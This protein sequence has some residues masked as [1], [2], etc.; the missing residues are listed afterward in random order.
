MATTVR[1]NPPCWLSTDH[2]EP[3]LIR[4]KIVTHAFVDG[5][6]R[7]VTG[8]HVVTNNRADTVLALFHA[9]I[10]QWG[11]PSR[12]R[13]DYGVEN[14]A[15]AQDQE[16]AKGPGRGSYIFGRYGY[17]Q[18][19]CR[20]SYS[21][22]SIGVFIISGSSDCGETSRQD[23]SVNGPTSSRTW[24]SIMV[25]MWNWMPTSGCYNICI[26]GSS[27]RTHYSGPPHGTNIPCVFQMV[28]PGG[29]RQ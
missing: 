14:Q 12:V 9:A 10:N 24:S 22:N 5:Y 1:L 8:I 17:Y 3:E 29:N 27:T 7:L 15:V 13:G 16:N 6:S 4:W 25:S 2:H 19:L 20:S 26:W 21:R 28:N 23:T 18:H 11:R